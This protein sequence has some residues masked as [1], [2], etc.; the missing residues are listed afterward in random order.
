MNVKAKDLA[1]GRTI[2]LDTDRTLERPAPVLVEMQ[3]REATS[4][5]EGTRLKAML[6]VDYP[7]TCEEHGDEI[8]KLP[9]PFAQA[10]CGIEVGVGHADG[11]ALAV[12][13]LIG[14]TPEFRLE[15]N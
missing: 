10:T 11:E 4:A 7:H 15:M 5:P 6:T 14:F 13:P 9:L 12:V 8:V 1:E 2:L 3:I